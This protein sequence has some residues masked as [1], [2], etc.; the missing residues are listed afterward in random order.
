MRRYALVVAGIVSSASARAQEKRRDMLCPPLPG[1]VVANDS[2]FVFLP[3]QVTKAA[4]W[5]PHRAIP[6][7]PLLFARSGIGGAVVVTFVVRTNGAVDS[8]TVR[9]LKSPHDSFTVAAKSALEV[10]RAHSAQFG[11]TRVRERV[12]HT[13]VFVPDTS[14][15]TFLPVDSQS[16]TTW[17]FALFRKRNNGETR[18]RL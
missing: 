12:S 14:Q 8:A 11:A 7:Y 2:S 1:P 6:V 10:W 18:R 5:L 9:V 15:R 13:F 4:E 3:C 17:V 16:D